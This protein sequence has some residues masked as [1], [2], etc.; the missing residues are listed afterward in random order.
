MGRLL[1][2]RADETIEE[3]TGDN[4]DTLLYE[5]KTK[6]VVTVRAGKYALLIVLTGKNVHM[7]LVLMNAQ[8]TAIKIKEYVNF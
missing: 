4:I 5:S 2:R 6:R 3:L 1:L 7:G 8:N